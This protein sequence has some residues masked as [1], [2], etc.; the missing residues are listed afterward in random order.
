[1]QLVSL[2]VLR[3]LRGSVIK[4]GLISVVQCGLSEVKMEFPETDCFPERRPG[5][6][7]KT[8][9]DR[10]WGYLVWLH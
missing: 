10:L 1:M 2:S 8:L 7:E 9:T 3:S 4:H 5:L 6:V